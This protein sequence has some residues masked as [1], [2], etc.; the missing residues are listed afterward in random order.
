MKT[1][2][3]PRLFIA[4]SAIALGLVTSALAMPPGGSGPDG[5]GR[6][7]H[8]MMFGMKGMM[9]LHDDLKL[10]A[11]QEAAWQQADKASKDAMAGMR[12]RMTRHHEE[13]KAMIDKPGTDL[14]EVAKRM[15]DFRVEG[16][17][18]HQE[19]RDRWFAVYDT[20]NP[21]Q[22]EKVRVFFK[23]MSERMGKMGERGGPH[24]GRDGRGPAPAAK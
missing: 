7:G 1:K 5:M 22:K 16:Q 13:I 18:L 20:L 23:G 24:G 6:P 14:R 4:T 15:D 21:E 12:E 10:D 8:H 19:N 17:K 11:R 3:S 2:F 9:R